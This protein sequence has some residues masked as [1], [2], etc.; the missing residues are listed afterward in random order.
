VA[1]DVVGLRAT[2]I[3]T[4]HRGQIRI[5][6]D[7]LLLVDNSGMISNIVEPGDEDR[8][9]VEEELRSAGRL[10][11]LG[12]GQLLLPGLVDLH[13]HAP[14]F[15]QL[16]KALDVPLDVWLMDQTFPLEARYAD[17]EFAVAVYR[18]LVETLL[19]NGTTTA[20]YFGTI[21]LSAT[22]RLVDTC[23]RQGQRALVGRVAMDDPTTCPDYYRDTS[24]ERALDETIELIEYI[25]G[26]RRN[27]NRLVLPVVTPRFIP[28][29]TDDMLQRLGEVA[30]SSGVH[31]QT[32]CSESDWAH[33]Y[34]LDRF[35]KTDTLSYRDFGLLSR[36]TILAHCNLVT[37]SDLEVIAETGAAIAHCP[38]SNV[39]FA[40]AV[41]PVR[42]A[43][44][45]GAH[46][47]LGTDIAGGYS[48]SL[49][50]AAANAVA[51]SRLLEDG[52][53]AT[54]AAELRGKAGS[55][56]AAADAFWLATAGGGIALDLP[57]GVLAPGYAF[58]A[59]VVDTGVEDTDL[60]LWPL[61]DSTEDALEKIILTATRRNIA[62]VWVQGRRVR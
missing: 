18:I 9:A 24:I 47:G 33:Q 41:F 23:L 52:V 38:L 57:I 43:L 27:R 15:P 60:H 7:A 4:P 25:T 58:D 31:V 13:I 54:V 49:F 6:D 61:L 19:A 20:A 8:S 42:K 1:P 51:S 59:I 14:Q 56:I 46:V 16:G 55:R 62:Q 22:K 50:N 48:P 3:D 39:F 12:P 36:R 37:S 26:H 28:S 21:H 44:E 10:Y 5:C 29:C 30:S 34:G 2:T 40:N 45:V 53:D 35:G 32:H 11:E 17:D